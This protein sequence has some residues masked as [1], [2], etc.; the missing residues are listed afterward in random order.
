M[1]P[2][3]S[4]LTTKP[5]RAA[6]ISDSKDFKLIFSTFQAKI[7]T[8]DPQIRSMIINGDTEICRSNLPGRI[9]NNYRKPKTGQSA[10]RPRTT[11]ETSKIHNA[12]GLTTQS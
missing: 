9:E 4:M 10:C 3:A 1:G 12:G 11:P 8:C 6:F 7:Q 2:E 5:P